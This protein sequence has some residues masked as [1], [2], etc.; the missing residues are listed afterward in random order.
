MRHFVSLKIL[1]DG[2]KYEGECNEQGLP[3]GRGINI[4]QNGNLYEGY[5][6]NGKSNGIGR[7]IY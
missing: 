5:F 2:T 7:V 3:H 1:E 4:S 6:S